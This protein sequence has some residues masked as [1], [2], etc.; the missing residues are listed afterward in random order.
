MKTTGI[1]RRLDDLGRVVLP[2]EL[3]R[4]FDLSE[5]DRVEIFTEDDKI[6]LKKFE[7]NCMFCGNDRNL[8]EYKG[9][10]ICSACIKKMEKL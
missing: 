4:S 1:V 8:K 6:I 9:K 5:H 7:P 3:R 10:L 2:I